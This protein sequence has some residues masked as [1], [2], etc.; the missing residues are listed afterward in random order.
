VPVDLGGGATAGYLDILSNG[1]VFVVPEQSWSDAQA[2]T[3]LDGVS[4]AP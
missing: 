1:E 2:F 4:F 3:S